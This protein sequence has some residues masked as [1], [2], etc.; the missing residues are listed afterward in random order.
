[1]RVFKNLFGKNFKMHVD[2]VVAKVNG[3]ARLLSF[4][5]ISDFN[6]NEAEGSY[7]KF[8]NGF[9][10]CWATRVSSSY[11]TVLNNGF[12]RTE[13]NEWRYPALFKE[14]TTPSIAGYSGTIGYGFVGM[15]NQTPNN[16]RCA[17]NIWATQS[18]NN[19]YPKAT[20]IAFGVYK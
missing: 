12:Y 1:M 15:G 13:T 17:F 18:T 5:I 8:G 4:L 2:E 6:F 19:T 7:I 11:A 9:M 10:I 20:M 16:A 14:G 3:T